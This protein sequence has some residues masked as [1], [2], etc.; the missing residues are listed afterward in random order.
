MKIQLCEEGDLVE[1]VSVGAEIEQVLNKDQHVLAHILCLVN[2]QDRGDT[3]FPLL[4]QECLEILERFL[5]GALGFDAE[6]IHD[7]A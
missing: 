1:K 3:G 4:N 5:V 7:E 6:L 2:Q